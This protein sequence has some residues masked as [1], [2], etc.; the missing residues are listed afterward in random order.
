MRRLLVPLLLLLVLAGGFGWWW[1]QPERVVARRITSLFEAAEVEDT[2]SEISRSTRGS[3]LE[4]FLAPNVVIRGTEEIE[5]YVDGPQSRDSLVTN[6][7]MAAR[8]SRRISFE[9][10]EVDEVIVTGDSATAK[11]RVDA[12][13]ELTNGNR[14]A[15][16]VLHLDMEWK[17][18][19]GEWVLSSVA[20]K[21]TGR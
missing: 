18:I 10:A 6:Y 19:D 16:G 7:T 14:P 4:K 3:S 9:P 5:E 17:K 13:I 15:D 20:W 12:I 21:E 1:Y 2:A 8:G 11:A